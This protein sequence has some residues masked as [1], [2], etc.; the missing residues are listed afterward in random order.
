MSSK[1]LKIIIFTCIVLVTIYFS[2]VSLI[3]GKEVTVPEVRGRMLANARRT[4]SDNGLTL[5]EKVRIYDENLEEGTVTAQEPLPGKCVKKGRRIFVT[6]SSGLKMVVVPDLKGQNF[7]QA[8]ILLS[9]SGLKMISLQSQLSSKGSPKSIVIAQNPLPNLEVKKNTPVEVT[10]SLGEHEKNFIMPDLAG[11]QLAAARK[12]LF[13]EKLLTLKILYKEDASAGKECVLRQNPLP[14][15][16]V[17]PGEMIVLTVNGKPGANRYHRATFKFKVPSGG[18]LEKRVRVSVMDNDG[19]RDIYDEI[20]KSG[21]VIEKPL[22]LNGAALVRI[23]LN[24]ELNR[25][26][27]YD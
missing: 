16:E 8:G 3:R 21:S 1:I 5:V 12:V 22:K 14:G 6:V 15:V 20:L 10:F 25:E 13:A 7:R 19:L 18:L 26:E 27:K 23:Y 4:C 17:K 9:Q 11:C 24:Y 2:M